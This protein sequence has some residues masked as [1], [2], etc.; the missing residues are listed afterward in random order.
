MTEFKKA[1]E[2][3][4]NYMGDCDLS[5]TKLERYVQETEG[6]EVEEPYHKSSFV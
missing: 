5:V 1:K 3:V 4:P 2:R 6:D